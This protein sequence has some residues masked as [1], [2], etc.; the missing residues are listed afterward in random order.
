MEN[1]RKTFK[2]YLLKEVNKD[3]IQKIQK[4]YESVKVNPVKIW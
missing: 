3:K 1:T 4:L 2:L